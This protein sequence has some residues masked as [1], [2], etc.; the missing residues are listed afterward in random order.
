MGALLVG[1][2]AAALPCMDNSE[3]CSS[4]AR[5]GECRANPDFMKV[6]CRKSCTLDCGADPGIAYV[7]V[8]AHGSQTGSLDN[9]GELAAGAGDVAVT[10]ERALESFSHL[11][12]T[13]LSSAPKL[14]VLQLDRF[15]S[16]D[17]VGAI[18]R[19]SESAS[20]HRSELEHGSSKSSQAWRTSSTAPCPNCISQVTSL[21]ERAANLT[22]VPLANFEATQLVEYHP[23]QCG[24]LCRKVQLPP[25]LL[26]SILSQPDPQGTTNSTL[27]TSRS[28][29]TALLAHVSILYCCT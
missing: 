2:A 11:E 4:W 22:R 6:N 16:D 24:K 21:F 28:I 8:D 3:H 29:S 20:W 25:S 17:E 19:I 5:S 12:P 13:M 23:K 9:E 10:F 27:T 15:A 7:S 18:V 26:T 14:P 1:I